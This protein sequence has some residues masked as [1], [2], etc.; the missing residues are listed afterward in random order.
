MQAVTSFVIPGA[1]I[2]L[3][4]VVGLQLSP[5]DFRRVA[6]SPRTVAVGTLGQFVVLPA[7]AGV[8]ILAL[9]PA[10][11]IAVGVI[12]IAA[13]PG[14]PMSNLLV[15]LAR[16]NIALSVTFTALTNTIGIITFP[17]VTAAGVRLFLGERAG[18]EIPLGTMMVQ[19]LLLML[20]PIA[21]GMV[22]RA[23]GPAF[24]ERH[25]ATLKRASLLIVAAIVM[26]I[27]YDQRGAFAV[28]LASAAGLSAFFTPS[29]MLIGFATGWLLGAALPDR[30][31]LAVEFPVRNTALAIVVAATTLGRLDYAVFIVAYFVVEMVIMM[32]VVGLLQLRQRG[33]NAFTLSD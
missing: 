8:A 14:A 28:H 30:I 4:W 10:E 13:A 23:R 12:L 5:V 18:V 27:A 7:I 29:A 32:G 11:A 6:Q 15:Y 9:R 17:L 33:A 31:T 25:R 20:L 19:L 24:V 1:V 16:G 22:V 26:F 3:M 21:V 2:F